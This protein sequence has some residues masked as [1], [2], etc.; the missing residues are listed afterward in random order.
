MR[1][2]R[3]VSMLTSALMATSPITVA[4]TQSVLIPWDPLLVLANQVLL[5]SLAITE[6]VH[7]CSSSS[8]SQASRAGRLIAGVE[9]S[10]SAVWAA[11]PSAAT[12]APGARPPPASASTTRALTPAAPAVPGAR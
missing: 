4:Q 1:P 3:A 12:P 8:S 9:T 10:T 5:I 7:I 6:S 2:T 11:T